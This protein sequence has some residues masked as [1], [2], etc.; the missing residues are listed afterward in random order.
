MTW[1]EVDL[2]SIYEFW[3]QTPS[4]ALRKMFLP[5]LSNDVILFHMMDKFIH[6][7]PSYEH[8]EKHVLSQ[9]WPTFKL[10]AQEIQRK[11][12]FFHTWWQAFEKT[13]LLQKKQKPAA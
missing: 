10:S 5:L 2:K 6:G 3:Q 1:S 4:Q 12:K 7:C 9:S 11:E 8:F 13:G